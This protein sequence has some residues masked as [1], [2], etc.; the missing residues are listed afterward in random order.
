MERGVGILPKEALIEAE[1]KG[2]FVVE[3]REDMSATSIDMRVSKL[4]KHREDIGMTTLDMDFDDMFEEVEPIGE[5]W[6]LEPNTIYPKF[7][8]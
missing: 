2:L 5:T 4:F 1:N 6:I 8:S 7:D 3:G